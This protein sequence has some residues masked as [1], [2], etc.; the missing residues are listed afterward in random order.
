MLAE[1][2]PI[3]GTVQ[4]KCV[5]TTDTSG[6]YGNPT[7]E[8]LSTSSA[9]GGVHPVVRY[10]VTLADAY[11]AKVTTPQAFTSSPV[12]VD[13]VVWTG[14]TVVNQTSTADMAGYEAAKIVYNATTEFDLTEAGSTWFKSASTAVYGY[15]KAFPGGSYNALVNAECIAK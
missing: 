14:S 8:K 10:D 3:T 7:P 6:V 4:S 11:L 13:T 15:D 5:I 12:L 2:V 1:E 9:H